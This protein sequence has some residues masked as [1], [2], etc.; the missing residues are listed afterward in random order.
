MYYSYKV[1]KVK[2]YKLKNDDDCVSN[3]TYLI[4]IK[5]ENKQGDVCRNISLVFKWSQLTHNDA[6]S[7]KKVLDYVVSQIDAEITAY[8]AA[9]TI[10]FLNNNC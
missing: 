7:F 1:I 3:R 6:I 2:D 8:Q 9:S 5:Y 4:K 10:P